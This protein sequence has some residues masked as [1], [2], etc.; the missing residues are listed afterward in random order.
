MD[1]LL[2]T[3]IASTP[4]YGKYAGTYKVAT[5]IRANGYSC[6]VVDNFSFYT[7]EQ[8]TNIVEKFCSNDTLMVGFSCTLSEKRLDGKVYNFGRPDEDFINL[9]KHIKSLNPNIKICLG[10]GRI[11]INSHWPGVD[12][13]VINKGDVAVIKLLDH[14]KHGTDIKTCKTGLWQVID[15]NDYFY[16]Q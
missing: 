1:V 2:F 15:G 13:T 10:G 7:Y 9:V 16:T 14:I 8:L 3:D 6:Q 4:G 5:E 11:N 12:F